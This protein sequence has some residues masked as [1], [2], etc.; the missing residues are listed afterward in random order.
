MN[1][2]ILIASDYNAKDC[3]F[4]S[5]SASF[6]EVV[7]DCD[8]VDVCAPRIDSFIAHHLL[9]LCA[10]GNDELRLQR[11]F[12]RLMNGFRKGFG[13]TGMPTIE[14]T[15]VKSDYDFFMF[16][17]W[18]A[19]GLTEINRI[20]GWKERCAKSAV[21]LHEAWASSLEENRRYLKILDQFDYVF[22]V[23]HEAVAPLQKYTKASCHYLPAGV[24]CTI[25]NPFPQSPKRVIDVYSIGNRSPEV[26]KK[27][28]E[29]SRQ[30]GLF[31]IYDSLA[32][33][34]SRLVDWREHRW[35]IANNIKRSK[36]FLAFSPASIRSFKKALINGEQVLPARLYEGTAGGTVLL[37]KAPQCTEFQDQFGWPD[38]LIETPDNVEE[39]PEFLAD[40]ERQPERMDRA[41]KTNAIQALKQHDWAYRW[42]SVLDTVGLQPTPKLANRKLRLLDRAL[43]IE[44]C[45]R[46]RAW[47]GN[48]DCVASE[49][50]RPN[51]IVWG[52]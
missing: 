14:K 15:R 47:S 19:P 44:N 18:D 49:G 22:T 37:G 33:S 7:S 39:L 13:F 2:R 27:L 9:S 29:L 41:R 46:P 42:E 30:D 31:Y 40:L 35:L 5:L 20:R 32:S 8:Y 3:A 50:T 45:D 36:Y 17:V 4:S 6:C 48:E 11:D 16:C 26:H 1:A 25:A 52:R 21:Y 34:D 10:A 12:N 28:V 23:H 43:Q 24:D 51:P 38:S